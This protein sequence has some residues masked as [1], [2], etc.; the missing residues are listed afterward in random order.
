VLSSPL[1]TIVIKEGSNCHEQTIPGSFKREMFVDIVNHFI[2]SKDSKPTT[3]TAYNEISKLS[4]YFPLIN[5]CSLK[6]LPKSIKERNS[7]FSSSS[8]RSTSNPVI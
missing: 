4:A 5:K 8:V 1:F 6:L 2:Q 7:Q 3:D